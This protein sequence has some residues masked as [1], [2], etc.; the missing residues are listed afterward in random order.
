[1]SALT[2]STDPKYPKY[3]PKAASF[4]YLSVGIEKTG[5][6]SYYMPGNGGETRNR[7]VDKNGNVTGT[8]EQ[9]KTESIRLKG[10][11]T[12]GKIKLRRTCRELAANFKHHIRVRVMLILILL[13]LMSSAQSFPQ[14]NSDSVRWDACL[15]AISDEELRNAEEIGGR[16][17]REEFLVQKCGFRP[18]VE[19]PDGRLALT[20]E[21]CAHL[22]AWSEDGE[23]TDAKLATY[24]STIVRQ[25]D[26]R[27][28]SYKE[29]SKRCEARKTRA[30]P[31]KFASF[32]KHICEARVER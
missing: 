23:C 15:E 27:I 12:I 32:R 14:S 1:M 28:F 13:L 22:Y 30:R 3:L 18:T 10:M 25:L 11:S 16:L 19:L 5:I 8:P 9:V 4:E 29:F 6:Y 26:P 17:G 21:D 7:H 2:L 31:D 24:Q 20:N